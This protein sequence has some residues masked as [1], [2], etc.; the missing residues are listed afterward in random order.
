MYTSK[1]STRQIL[2][3]L[4]SIIFTFGLN[5]GVLLP[6]LSILLEEQGIAASWNGVNASILYLGIIICSPFMETLLNRFG[7]KPM[8]LTGI[9]LSIVIM[10]SFPFFPHFGIWL[11]LRLFMGICGHMCH[12]STIVWLTTVAPINL[13]GRYIAY[14]GFA[15]GLGF[16]LGPILTQLKSFSIYI[17]FAVNATLTFL[18]LLLAFKLSNEFPEKETDTI[19][20]KNKV[21]MYKKVFRISWFAILCTFSYGFMEAAISGSLPIYLE[22]NNLG[23]SNTSWI[24][25]MFFLSGLITQMPI[26]WLSDKFDRKYVILIAVSFGIFGFLMAAITKSSFWNLILFLTIAGMGVGSIYSLGVSFMTDCTPKSL[27]PKGNI[28]CGVFF[29]VG[30][31]L[32]PL[33]GGVYIQ[34]LPGYHFAWLFVI[35]FSILWLGLFIARPTKL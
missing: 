12:Y 18:T 30:S 21:Q 31:I 26:G 35:V 6:L 13:R 34:F 29:S 8:L 4:V 33:S 17:P 11:A 10:L 15:F 20:Q 23:D 2:L 7:Y 16:S 27:L 24:L 3:T 5:S 19:Q 9:I 22:R 1:N 28:L 32:G 25:M 14:Y